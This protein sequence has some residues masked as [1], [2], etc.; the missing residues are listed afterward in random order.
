MAT[1][2]I[3]VPI[4]VLT[5]DGDPHCPNQVEVPTYEPKV[6]RRAARRAGWQTVSKRLKTTEDL[7]RR[8]KPRKPQGHHGRRDA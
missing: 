6:L 7:C 3:F 4:L 1:E 8:H 2:L 5:C